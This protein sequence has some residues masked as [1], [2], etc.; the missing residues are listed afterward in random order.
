LTTTTPGTAQ[1]TRAITVAWLILSAIT[2][3]SWWLAPGH[4]GGHTTASIP[5]TVAAILLGFIKGRMIIRYFME[6]RSAP[7]WLRRSTD[8]WLV[9]LW[10]SILVIYLW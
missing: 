9:V 8:L 2:V 10:T 4:A 6:V 5:I 3:M 7:R 1:S